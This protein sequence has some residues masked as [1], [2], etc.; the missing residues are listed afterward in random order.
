MKFC[1]L[2]LN[3]QLTDCLSSL[4]FI[5]M[6]PVQEKAIPLLLKGDSA[7]V[8]APTGSGKTFSYLVPILNSL[9]ATA[10]TEAV[11]IVPTAILV[12]QV[13][14]TLGLFKKGYR[15]FTS[16]EISGECNKERYEAKILVATPDRFLFNLPKMNLKNVKYLIID[17]GD[18]I[19][20]GGFKEQLTTILGLDIKAKKYLF[21]AS[22]DEQ[23]NR[24][25]R[26]FIG[27][28]K[29]VDLSKEEG[30]NAA[31]IT[32]YMVDI[33]HEDKA[34][35]LV[36]FLKFRHVYKAI[37]FCSKNDEIPDTDKALTAAGIEHVTI[38]G[39]MEKRDQARNYR[40]FDEGKVSL[41]LASDIAARGVDLKDVSDVISLDLPYDIMYYFHR[42]GR[43]GRFFKKGNSYVFYSNDDTSKAKELIRRGIQFHF[44]SLREEGLKEERDLSTL[45]L[46]PKK[47]NEYVEKA[48]KA[49]LRPLRTNKVRPNYKKKRRVAIM[50]VKKYHKDDIIR[51]NIARRNEEEGTS[52][53]FV[54]K[55]E[56]SFRN[57][58]RRG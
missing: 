29:I 40:F 35:A 51:K 53:S 44:L 46:R 16:E 36:N 48:I 19:I 4:G 33:R 56:P 20:F 21:T 37:V 22:V 45:E 12:H 38:Y 57:K 13:N 54:S 11:I 15:D 23:M 9:D 5:D 10:S 8:K 43:A 2:G 17:E 50:L 28:E 27:A 7:L 34:K 52:F 41:L 32:H 1:E 47:N 24:L 6:S 30:I 25:V 3:P 14:E 55:K 58:K 26:R 42:A 39:E 49:R 31:N 18:M